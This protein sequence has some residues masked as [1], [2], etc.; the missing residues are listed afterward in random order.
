[1]AEPIGIDDIEDV[2]S[3]VR[4]LVSLEARP[5][6]RSR[7]LGLD[8]LLLTPALRVVS[9]EPP[10]AE[11]VAGEPEAE[12]VAF[13]EMTEADQPPF[14]MPLDTDEAPML[15]V[16]G[17]WGHAF[18]SETEPPLAE[19]ALGAEDAELVTTDAALLPEATP[20]P[21]AQ[22]YA[23]WREAEVEPEPEREPEQG[24]EGGTVPKPVPEPEPETV[25]ELEPEPEMVPEPEPEM[26]PEPEPEMVPEILPE[27][28]PEIAPELKPETVPEL[29]VEPELEPVSALVM[30]PEPVSALAPDLDRASPLEPEAEP[31]PEPELAVRPEQIV[32]AEVPGV[33]DI[34]P[35]LT[36]A[37]GNPV[38]VLD[39][40]ALNEMVRALIREE[41]QGALGERITHNVRK[42]VRAEINRALAARSLD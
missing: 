38:T 16:E 18:W 9:D 5:R 40:A 37:D 11:V 41:L 17:E 19:I 4:R 24:P 1:M 33:A 35:G 36:D 15:V 12:V 14:E 30:E 8:L 21:F 26:V 7:E 31:A 2:V 3:S 10:V 6:A 28:E 34:V 42:L 23:G 39:E 22:E 25:P 32:P 20:V 13:D 27:L 29:V